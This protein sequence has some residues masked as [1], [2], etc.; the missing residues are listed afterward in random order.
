MG[1]GFGIPGF[2]G[3]AQSENDGSQDEEQDEEGG[4]GNGM[5]GAGGFGG[6]MRHHG[7]GQSNKRGGF[8]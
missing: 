4:F 1:G 2:G 3:N 7:H 6:R 5:F 8:R